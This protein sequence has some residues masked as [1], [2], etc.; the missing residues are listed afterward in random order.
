MEL[1]IHVQLH[2]PGSRSFLVPIVLPASSTLFCYQE[3][4]PC[5]T[6]L[7]RRAPVPFAAGEPVEGHRPLQD[8]PSSK[9][10]RVPYPVRSGRQ[11]M[12]QEWGSGRRE[13][14]SQ[15]VLQGRRLATHAMV[16]SPRAEGEVG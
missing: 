15:T 1:T 4:Q 12:P 10:L 8:H 6:V 7:S 9:K 2:D 14:N 16:F 11:S 3:L 13:P 5:T